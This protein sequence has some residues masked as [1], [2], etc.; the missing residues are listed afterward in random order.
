V[1]RARQSDSTSPILSLSSFRY[2]LATIALVG[3]IAQFGVPLSVW[4][5]K[6]HDSIRDE[7]YLVGLQLKDYQRAPQPPAGSKS[8]S[9]A[10]VSAAASTASATA[11]AASTAGAGL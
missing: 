6:M 7:Q 11:A 3:I 1:A 5:Q 2:G 4:F 9:S 10:A 8:A